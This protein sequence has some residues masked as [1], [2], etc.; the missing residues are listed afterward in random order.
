MEINEIPDSISDKKLENLIEET[1]NPK[2]VGVL[3]EMKKISEN[4]RGI[5]IKAAIKINNEKR[6]EDERKKQIEDEKE[7]TMDK[8]CLRCGEIPIIRFKEGFRF[9]YRCEKCGYNNSP[10]FSTK[11]AIIEFFNVSEEEAE[12]YTKK[13][14]NEKKRLLEKNIKIEFFEFFEQFGLIF[15]KNDKPETKEQ[16]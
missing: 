6:I 11:N 15:K 3:E 12:D 8:K 13:Y 9:Y 14:F 2:L 10:F 5:L 4:S 7:A 16:T 1:E